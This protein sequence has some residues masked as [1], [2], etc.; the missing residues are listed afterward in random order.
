MSTAG[1]RAGIVELEQ[2]SQAAA[3]RINT[4]LA[5]GSFAAGIANKAK[6][7]AAELAKYN[8]GLR[9]AAEAAVDIGVVGSSSTIFNATEAKTDAQKYGEWWTDAI[10]K[11][12]L[13]EAA[14]KE[15]QLR[16]IRQVAIAGVASNL[17]GGHGF[18]VGGGPGGGIS[19]IM[20]E[21]L[22]I[23]RE[24]GRN[25]FSRIPGSVTLL[26]QYTGVLGTLIKSTAADAIK[27][28]AAENVLATSMAR[29]A[30]AAEAKASAARRAAM[31][32]GVDA[33]AAAALVAANEAEAASATAASVAQTKKA[34]AA[35]EAAEIEN[36][37]AS[38]SFSIW[39]LLVAALV[40][41]AA[42]TYFTYRH[43]KNLDKAL[44]D[45]SDLADNTTKSYREQADAI[46]RSQKTIQSETDRLNELADA[47][48]NVKDAIEG[49]LK[50]MK[51]RAELEQRL[52]EAKGANG[53]QITQM[54]L[55][56]EQE[57]LDFLDKSNAALKQK[58]ALD[59]QEE[60]AAN[61]RLAAFQKG[62]Q[63]MEL[64]STA[65]HVN[66]LND[67]IDAARQQMSQTQIDTGQNYPL[68]SSHAGSAILRPANESD[69]L[70]FKIGGKEYI[71]SVAHLTMLL[72]NDS[73]IV[74]HLS[75]SQKELDDS[76]GKRKKATDEDVNSLQKYT[77]Q[78]QELRDSLKLHQELLPQIAAAENAK[79]SIRSS[80]RTSDSLVQVGNFLGTA[81]GKIES[82][83][84]EANKIARE[85]LTV[86]KRIESNTR[87]RNGSAHYSVT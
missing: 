25:N 20:R 51:E 57:Q 44:Q 18:G 47:E 83:A 14:L 17:F 36:A 81:R 53:S 72:K 15:E 73:E 71:D 65:K 69:V 50:V 64:E 30:L 24:I 48:Y 78:S 7:D 19:G 66:E 77:S 1:F 59:E 38:V 85:Q 60:Q 52:A 26:A 79:S 63:G 86:S 61:D 70:T 9:G 10:K 74:A 12:E 21:S 16:G 62:E 54:Q 80:S 39:G 5:R 75:A 27:A 37:A 31:A 67:I 3:V 49:T 4:A 6:A 76:L 23:L 13:A 34:K 82:L 29:T 41:V 40:A 56:A 55:N 45:T 58:I 2:M 35:M 28:A 84:E 68:F 33:E 22:V 46:E 43:Y 87:S 32:E 11:R 8:Q 42:A